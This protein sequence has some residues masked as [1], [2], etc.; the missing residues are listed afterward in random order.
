MENPPNEHMDDL[1]GDMLRNHQSE[2]DDV[3]WTN[4]QANIDPLTTTNLKDYQAEPDAF[5]W[6]NIKEQIPNYKPVFPYAKA[7]DLAAL[8]LLVLGFGLFQLET[9]RT[10]QFI[11]TID[12]TNSTRDLVLNDDDLATIALEKKTIGQVDQAVLNNQSNL[13]LRTNQNHS[14]TIDK[15]V[16]S[17]IINK[18]NNSTTNLTIP[19]TTQF[20]NSSQPNKSVNYVV[21]KQE[22]GTQIGK[23]FKKNNNI[24]ETISLLNGVRN[25]QIVTDEIGLTKSIQSNLETGSTP[26][27]VTVNKAQ[28]VALTAFAGYS[29]NQWK[30]EH[31]EVEEHAEW[32]GKLSSQPT[33]SSGL[34]VDYNIHKQLSIKTGAIYQKFYNQIEKEATIADT[35]IQLGEQYQLFNIDFIAHNHS[36]QLSAK[37][38]K[39]NNATQAITLNAEQTLQYL[40]IPLWLNYTINPQQRL[41]FG[42]TAGINANVLMQ[43]KL[44]LLDFE[45]SGF[46]LNDFSMVD[47]KG[48]RDVNW[49]YTTGLNTD[50]RLNTNWSLYAQALHTASITKINQEHIHRNTFRNLTINSGLVFRF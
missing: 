32:D 31:N 30:I 3:I 41:Q 36:Y 15:A 50:Y 27:P 23:T 18:Q 48:L 1:F 7:F 13:Q 17:T 37:G 6:D 49:S 33:I 44:E 43:N 29:F 24:S 8:C 47:G 25:N 26:L 34:L 4:I 5:V 28:K 46:Y 2:P 16:N 21:T 22:L 38:R 9:T 19:T 14:T 40:S 20:N 42:V 11:S 35:E 39:G 45:V 12:N 10:T